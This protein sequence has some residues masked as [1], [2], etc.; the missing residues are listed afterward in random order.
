[1]KIEVKVAIIGKVFMPDILQ[2]VRDRQKTEGIREV[3]YLTI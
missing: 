1:M 3:P 2:R